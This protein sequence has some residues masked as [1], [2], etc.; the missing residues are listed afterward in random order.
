MEDH[1]RAGHWAEAIPDG[2]RVAELRPHYDLFHYQLGALLARSGDIDGYRAHCRKLLTKYAKT[3]IAMWAER[4][5]KVCLIL[6]EQ[7]WLDLA[8]ELADRSVSGGQN[9]SF[10]PYYRTVA[11][12]ACYRRGQYQKSV[13]FCD[14]A[15]TEKAKVKITEMTTEELNDPYRDVQVHFIKS[16]ALSRLGKS[17][18]A[19]QIHDKGIELQRDLYQGSEKAIAIYGWHDMAIG[20]LLQK[21]CERVLAEP[22]KAPA[23]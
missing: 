5:A 1:I 14:L 22:P 8:C 15:L 6:P 18:E 19:K 9:E 23:P 16:M 3:D 2:K 4:T 13:E 21:E 10:L 11:A 7:E 12:L 20:E 17:T